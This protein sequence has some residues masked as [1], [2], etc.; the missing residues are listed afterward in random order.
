VTISGLADFLNI[1][2]PNGYKNFEEEL[3]S[4]FFFRSGRN[5]EIWIFLLFF[6]KSDFFALDLKNEPKSKINLSQFVEKYFNF[7]FRF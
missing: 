7:N 5:F 6:E 1:F 4:G 2:S 3:F